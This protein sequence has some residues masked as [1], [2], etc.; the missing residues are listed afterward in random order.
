MLDM[1]SNKV[2]DEEANIPGL[3]DVDIDLTNKKIAGDTCEGSLANAEAIQTA[4]DERRDNEVK[5]QA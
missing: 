4:T 5:T 1:R 2:W 3:V